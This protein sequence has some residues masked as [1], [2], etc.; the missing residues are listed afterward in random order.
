MRRPALLP[1][2]LLVVVVAAGC[3]GLG[4]DPPVR[5]DRAVA[6]LENA[7]ETARSVDSYA[8][9]MR[10]GIQAETQERT[11]SVTVQ[12][13]GRVNAT[14]ETMAMTSEV[15]GETLKGYIDGRR[16]YEQC[17]PSGM[18]WGQENVTAA[19]W[20]RATPLGR[21][22][23]LLSTGDL[24][25]NETETLDGREVIHLTGRPSLSA[26]RQRSDVGAASLPDADRIEDLEVEAWIDAATHRLVR[27]RYTATAAGSEGSATA[28]V[29]LSFGDYGTPVTVT[30]PDEARDAFFDGGC[31]S[32]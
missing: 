29:E 12:G 19:N 22:L 6:V 15:Q 24:Y 10:F 17:P 18:H 23:A 8:F 28:T 2:A 9:D 14:A 16:A 25:Y 5:E 4:G 20:S 1:I 7:S 31:P 30:V 26:L 32:G 13:S 3:L 27:S 21:Q 11:R